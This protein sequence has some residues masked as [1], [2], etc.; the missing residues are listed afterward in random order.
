MNIDELKRGLA[1]I[2]DE[3]EDSGSLDRL[4][5]V[6]HKAA[7]QRRAR[8]LGT[9]LVAAVAVAAVALAPSV[10]SRSHAPTQPA[11]H[12]D[13]M[14]TVTQRGVAFYT[15]PA[16]STL[17]G[18]V[19]AVPGATRVSFTFTPNTLDLGWDDECWDP[20]VKE[21]DRGAWYS[22]S[23]NGHPLGSS[24]CQGKPD[25]GPLSA[26]S[27]FSDSPTGNGRGWSRLGVRVGEPST[28][29][30]RITKPP[31]LGAA[32][33]MVAGV[34]ERGEHLETDG[35]W[36]DRQL[37]YRGHAYQA[38]DARVAQLD[39]TRVAQATVVLPPSDHPLYVYRGAQHVTHGLQLAGDSAGLVQLGAGVT[40]GG[41]G[42]TVAV[43]RTHAVV[44]AHPKS[45][46]TRGQIFVLVYERID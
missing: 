20:G 42:H 36:Y 43:G 5:G 11:D 23:V 19:A 35:V 24:T 22:A 10:V 16:G 31:G 39:G 28:F 7:V 45:P 6:D 33:Q 38:V 25:G 3:V 30:V 21:V 12:G 14:P 26:T 32:P 4:A 17:I 18:H 44:R 1:T 27:F 41:S 13:G 9:G 8:V 46:E 37:V 40:G 15:Q 2:A 29:T 34:W